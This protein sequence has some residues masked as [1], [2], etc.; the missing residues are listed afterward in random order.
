MKWMKESF[1]IWLNIIEK[2]EV[3][4]QKKDKKYQRE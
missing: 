1:K 2:G 4:N 3:E